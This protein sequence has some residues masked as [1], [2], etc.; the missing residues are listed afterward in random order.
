[1]GRGWQGLGP[2]F[3]LQRALVWGSGSVA[4]QR[5]LGW[6]PVSLPSLLTYACVQTHG[7]RFFTSPR[8]LQLRHKEAGGSGDPLPAAVA[9]ISKQYIQTVRRANQLLNSLVQAAQ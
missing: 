3:A 5:A 9:L 6:P 7:G 1:M 8:Q 2:E 4:L